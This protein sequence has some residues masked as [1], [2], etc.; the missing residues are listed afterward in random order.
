MHDMDLSTFQFFPVL[1]SNSDLARREVEAR[2]IGNQDSS[3]VHGLHMKVYGQDANSSVSA[4]VGTSPAVRPYLTDMSKTGLNTALDDA[5]HAQLLPVEREPHTMNGARNL[6]GDN[7]DEREGWESKVRKRRRGAVREVD[8]QSLLVAIE[9][10]G[11]A[12][13]IIYEP[14]RRRWSTLASIHE[15]EETLTHA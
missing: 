5:E 12:L 7:S 14:V 11:W 4:M 13:L 3:Q 2:T 9:R 6:S 10:P 15:W 1:S 8:A